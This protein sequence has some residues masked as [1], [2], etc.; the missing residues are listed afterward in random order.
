MGQHK[1]DS[2][3]EPQR[4]RTGNADSGGR[5]RV[6][7]P[8]DDDRAGIWGRPSGHGLSPVPPDGADVPPEEAT[9][10]Q[11]GGTGSQ[12]GLAKRTATDESQDEGHL[13]RG[14]LHGRHPKGRPNDS[15][16]GE[17]NA[18]PKSR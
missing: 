17:A 18:Q 15:R 3:S 6:S 14:E 9:F 10:S 1:D 16:R 8:G 5:S 7:N 11:G 2:K 13:D 12:P 4:G